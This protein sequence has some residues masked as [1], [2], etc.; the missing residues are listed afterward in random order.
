MDYIAYDPAQHR[1]WVPAGNTGLV[2]VIDARTGLLSQI[3]GFPISET[4]RN[5]KK[6]I[7]GPSSAAVGEG[8]VYIGN[9][10]DSTVCAVDA[11]TLKK[12]GMKRTISDGLAYVASMK[13]LWVTSPHAK[14]II[15]LDTANGLAVKTTIQLDGQPEGFA[16]DD[17]LGALLYELGRP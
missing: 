10:G 4:E 8:F 16:V 9:R 6:R 11:A 1:V 14:S 17:G 5:G 12:G 2:D 13:E 3:A 15:V 7:M